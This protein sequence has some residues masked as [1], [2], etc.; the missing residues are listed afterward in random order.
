MLTTRNASSPTVSHMSLVTMEKPSGESCSGA[1]ENST[2]SIHFIVHRVSKKYIGQSF[3]Y[4]NFGKCGLVFIIFSLLY[5]EMKS[6]QLIETTGKDW[7]MM[8]PTI[9]RLRT[10]KE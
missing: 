6:Q 5:S 7:F 8:Q 1:R 3:F 9:K 2:S 10:P 4:D